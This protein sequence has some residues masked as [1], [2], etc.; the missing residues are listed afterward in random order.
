MRSP[1]SGTV[2]SLSMVLPLA[3]TVIVKQLVSATCL[4]SH[5]WFWKPGK[6]RTPQGLL[7]KL[8]LGH[9]QHGELVGHFAPLLLHSASRIHHC[10]IR[11]HAWGLWLALAGCKEPPGLC[12]RT[13]ADPTPI[14][15][16]LGNSIL[17][18][19]RKLLT[20]K[21]WAEANKS[22]VYNFTFTNY[23][24]LQLY[25]PVK[26]VEQ[27]TNPQWAKNIV[28]VSAIIGTFCEVDTVKQ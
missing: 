20:G 14:L 25:W 18:T 28:T 13:K 16:K 1:L 24:L 5:A 10:T 4:W 3:S 8:K 11:I 2:R 12:G 26:E 19:S 15:E 9:G 27:L 17:S 23:N 6:P 7:P 21:K 22:K